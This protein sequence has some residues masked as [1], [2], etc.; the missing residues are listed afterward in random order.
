MRPSNYI[1]IKHFEFDSEEYT[2]EDVVFPSEYRNG[3]SVAL[4]IIKGG[5]PVLVLSAAF[6]T[7]HVGMINAFFSM[8]QNTGAEAV[9]PYQETEVQLLSA[10]NTADLAAA[11]GGGD[12]IVAND[13]LLPQGSFGADFVT[14]KKHSGEISVY[15]VREGDTLSQI[16]EMFGVT[17]NTILWAN[18]LSS[19]AAIQP[20]DTLIILPIVGVRH[21][22]KEGDTISSIAKKYE[23]DADE[24]LSYNQLASASDLVSGDTLVIP[25]GQVH[26]APAVKTTKKATP[27]RQTGAS[28]G[29]GSG[30]VHPAPGTIKTQG[31]HGYNAVDLAGPVG[32]AVLAAAAGEVIVSKGSGWNGGYGQYIVI[33]HANGVQTLY[34]HL[35]QNNVGVGSYVS[36]GSTIGAIGLTGKTT[37]AHVHFEVRGG[38]NPF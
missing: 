11:Q 1:Y 3:R 7:V 12:L 22:V 9:T 37:G 35:S 8:T 36:A 14:E 23:G 6:F 25:G 5:V 30:L 17:S 26:Q 21:V 15:V 24:I 10:A 18:D 33:K 34:S 16:A 29:S 27:T 19:A 38:T 28:S 31:I 20:G 2:H 13:A 32:T 4:S